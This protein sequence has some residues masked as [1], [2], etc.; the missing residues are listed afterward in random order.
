MAIL[1]LREFS[2]D[3]S[4]RLDVVRVIASVLRAQDD[5]TGDLE[6][7]TD[8]EVLEVVQSGWERDRHEARMTEVEDPT[9]EHYCE[10]SLRQVRSALAEGIRH[11]KAN[12]ARATAEAEIKSLVGV[13]SA[14]SVEKEIEL[15]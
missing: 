9:E 11:Q 4:S 10:A 8:E 13:D 15:E 12:E 14:V 1:T 2:L 3:T 7:L 6:L 5:G